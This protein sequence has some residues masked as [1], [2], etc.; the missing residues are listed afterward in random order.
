MSRCSPMVAP[1]L[2]P[3]GA[4]GVGSLNPTP[5]A[6]LLRMMIVA[7]AWSA[8]G[9]AIRSATSPSLSSLAN[10]GCLLPG[11]RLDFRFGVVLAGDAVHLQLSVG[12]DGG[13]RVH[14]LIFAQDH[15]FRAAWMRQSLLRG[16]HESTPRRES[17]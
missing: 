3:T 12:T 16:E 13:D 5:A 15:S 4:T 8:L 6:L 9:R 2:P 14:H 10:I 17:G 1:E 7:A 11:R